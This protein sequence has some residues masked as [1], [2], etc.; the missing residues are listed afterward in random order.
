MKMSRSRKILMAI[1]VIAVLAS[2]A[3]WAFVP[4]LL[5]RDV[6][7]TDVT[8]PDP[9]DQSLALRIWYPA[10]LDAR[11]RPDRANLPLIVISHG[12]GGGLNGHADTAIALARSGYVVAAMNHTGDN[13]RDDSYIAKGKHLIGRPRHV[14]RVVDFMLKVWPH[15]DRIDPERIGMFGHSAGGFTALI[16]AGAVPDMTLGRAHC[17]NRPDAWDCQ[18][19]KKH[20]FDVEKAKAPPD[21]AWVHDAR[22]RSIAIAAPAIAYAFAPDRLADVR[23][24]V[25]LWEAGHDDVVEDSPELIRK[26]L[27]HDAVDHRA[28]PG[29]GHFSFLA[30]CSLGFHATIEIMGLFGTPAICDDPAGF[31]RTGFHRKFNAALI[32]YF[33]KTLPPGER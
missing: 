28:I 23:V 8:V 30:P 22:I 27:A 1:A 12:T 25:Q 32:G 29:A 14:S 26:L 4:A 3:A 24:P 11:N 2:L 17:R 5:P 16:M 7:V 21:G 18:Y 31:D 33:D 6:H 15:R 10:S 19:L 13:Y 9:G 20:G